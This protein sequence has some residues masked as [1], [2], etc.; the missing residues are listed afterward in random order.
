MSWLRANRK[1]VI[2]GAVVVAIVLFFVFR[3]KLPGLSLENLI[4]DL[5]SSLGSWTYLLVG[6]LAFLETGAFVGLVAPGEFTVMLG[7]AVASQG[8][9]SL[10]LILA[11][12]WFC[13]F[14]G[15]SVSFLLGAK[16]GRGFL[17]RH[18]P[19]F[20]I[21]HER[22]DQV[23]G[24]F[25]KHGG[26]TILIGRFIGLVRA[27]APFIAG[28]SK[29][30]YSAFAPF[31]VLGTGLWSTGLILVGYFAAQ[32]LDT[33]TKIVGRG[34]FVFAIVVGVIVGLVAAL[35]FLRKP[36]NRGKVAAEMERRR[37]LRPLLALLRR[38][39]PQLA[40]IWRRLTP[41]GLGLELTTLLA[42]LSV[43]LFVL[44]AYWTVVAGDPGPTAG[45]DM[46][47]DV[48]RDLQTGWLVDVAKAVT[49][50]GSGWV[51]VALAV[52]AGAV[53]AMRRRWAEFLV[54]AIGMTLTVSLG[55]EIKAL[56]DRP[57]PPDPLVGIDGSS[58]P[59]GHAAQATL[60]TWLAVTFALR[61]VPGLARR[62]LVIAAGIALMIVIGLTRVYLRAHWL[63]DVSAGWAL[64]LSC[65]AAVAAVVV[66]I[67]HIRD[68]AP[69][70][71]RADQL[72]P[73][74]GA[75]AGH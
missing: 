26:K 16:L 68:N 59:S 21:S 60:Y 40:F 42:A 64:G 47:L 9:V 27:L 24:Y 7:G 62:T 72:R 2:R 10:P 54:L 25:T 28:S 52:L 55:P 45:D 14:L 38:L 1:W 4:E 50:L 51:T 30:R 73:G 39:R 43:G 56:T 44:I 41:G 66:V 35:R 31:S 8:D 34:L 36:E 5:S 74:A 75:G 3:D 53:L 48:S 19:R 67:A 37:A 61:L 69:R 49:Q 12:T 65:F 23:D 32:S 63:S 17:E 18:G 29:M 20:R 22:L 11:V 15:D 57:R 58:F 13:A 33:V 46:A 6:G 71:E 70:H